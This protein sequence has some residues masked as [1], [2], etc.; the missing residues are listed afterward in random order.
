MSSD[1]PSNTSSSSEATPLSEKKYCFL[2]R[3]PAHE[4]LGLIMN[5]LFIGQNRVAHF[6][7]KL[8]QVKC[9]YDKDKDQKIINLTLEIDKA[10]AELD[11]FTA[12]FH[13]YKKAR[14]E[15]LKEKDE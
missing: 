7:R 10:K 13:E 11:T 5:G 14:N 3:H 1:E 4:E 12:K 8:E 6:K 2:D 15:K 9:S